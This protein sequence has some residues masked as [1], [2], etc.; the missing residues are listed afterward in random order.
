MNQRFGVGIRTIITA[1]AVGSADAPLW[2][3]GLESTTDQTTLFPS[4]LVVF[5]DP[6][7]KLPST[8]D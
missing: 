5:F 2:L 6:T 4:S 8:L 3:I 7:T 1:T